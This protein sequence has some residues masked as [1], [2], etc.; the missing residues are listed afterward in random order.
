MTLKFIHIKVY[1]TAS[2]TRYSTHNVSSTENMHEAPQYDI[3]CEEGDDYIA[4]SGGVSSK[5]NSGYQE[6]VDENEFL[7]STPSS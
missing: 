1:A 3:P 6:D 2:A 5:I 4:T 7:S